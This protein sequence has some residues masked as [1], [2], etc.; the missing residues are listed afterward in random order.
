M[1]N[2]KKCSYRADSYVIFIENNE[3][4]TELYCSDCLYSLLNCRV[5]NLY[6]SEYVE[7]GYISELE[8]RGI[9]PATKYTEVEKSSLHQHVLARVA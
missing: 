1:T 6:G 5:F 9:F 3:K 2:C 4:K 7:H 8:R